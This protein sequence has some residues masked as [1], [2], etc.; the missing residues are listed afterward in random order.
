MIETWYEVYDNEKVN[1]D[2]SILRIQ[3]IL[4]KRRPK[5]YAE[6]LQKLNKLKILFIVWWLPDIEKRVKLFKYIY[7]AMRL[8]DDICDWD[9]PKKLS[10]V[11]KND[12]AENI[13]DI[14]TDRKELLNLLI[15]EIFILSDD[16]QI[17]E[18]V[19]YYLYQII[20]SVKFDL[21]RT[22]N[23]KEWVVSK[24][25]LN[26]NFYK[27]DIEWTI[28][29]TALIFWLEVKKSINILKYLWEATRIWY[30]LEDFKS[31]I[32]NKIINIPKEDMEKYHVSLKDLKNFQENWIICRGLNDWFFDQIREIDILLKIHS[33][34]I[35][36]SRFD[37]I[38]TPTFWWKYRKKL[39]LCLLKKKTF[40]GYINETVN[41]RRKIN[42]ILW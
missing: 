37:T 9:T 31:D 27:M 28:G 38:Y 33:K 36:Y 25:D 41:T 3:E 24:N 19:S 2:L 30:N 14:D 29:L 7:Y 16:L 22:I 10:N 13:C 34:K 17:L 12:L 35:L 11:E 23:N 42:Y 39:Y 18:E 5:K 32:S 20:I 40:T 15:K 26:Q 1:I 4:S 21:Y 6:F 8:L